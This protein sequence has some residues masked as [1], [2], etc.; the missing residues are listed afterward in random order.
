MKLRD[1]F[2]IGV[3]LL[4]IGGVFF[5]R[6]EKYKTPTTKAIPKVDPTNLNNRP[7]Y[8]NRRKTLKQI[9]EEINKPSNKEE[10]EI[11]ENFLSN[12]NEEQ[13]NQ[14]RK[15]ND[16]TNQRHSLTLGEANDKESEEEKYINQSLKTGAM[17]YVHCL[18][19]NNKCHH[20]GCSSIKIQAPINSDV[21]VTIKKN[22]HVFRHAY[23]QANDHYTFEVPDGVYQ[24]FFYYGKGWNPNKKMKK[25]NQGCILKGGFTANEHVSKSDYK[26][27]KNNALTYE[28]ILQPNGNFR[29]TPSNIEEAL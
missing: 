14:E 26:Q 23:I 17:P 20:F 16:K 12:Y 21:L 3:A 1:I 13:K 22:G 9:Q 24:T 18:G 5:E 15:S 2:I 6:E 4:I 8:E 25:T 29:P 11:F 27:L 10:D 19:K 28:L 7:I